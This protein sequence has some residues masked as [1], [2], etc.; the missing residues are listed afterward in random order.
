MKCVSARTRAIIGSVPVSASG[1]VRGARIVWGYCAASA[2]IAESACHCGV[3][4]EPRGVHRCGGVGDVRDCCV[5]AVVED[6]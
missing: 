4:T 2:L 3:R 5:R 1:A 6:H